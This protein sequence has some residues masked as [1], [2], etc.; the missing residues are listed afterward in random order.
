MTELLAVSQ[1]CD[2]WGLLY[3]L[4]AFSSW[5]SRDLA[6]LIAVTIWIQTDEKLH[7]RYKLGRYIV[8]FSGRNWEMDF[9]ASSLNA[10]PRW[11][12]TKGGGAH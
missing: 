11:G 2:Y 8:R 12:A 6:V 4:V 1:L 10:G 7:P 5:L 9:F 3:F